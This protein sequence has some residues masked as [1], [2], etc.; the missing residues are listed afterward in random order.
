MSGSF[1]GMSGAVVSH[2]SLARGPDG[3]SLLTLQVSSLSFLNFWA[4]RASDGKFLKDSC[5]VWILPFVA[6]KSPAP[7]AVRSLFTQSSRCKKLGAVI[8][9]PSSAALLRWTCVARCERLGSSSSCTALNCLEM[10][11]R[12]MRGCPSFPCS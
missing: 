4:F 3:A 5:A 2:S 6:A 1:V 9:F 8:V 12:A 7:E 11:S 10:R